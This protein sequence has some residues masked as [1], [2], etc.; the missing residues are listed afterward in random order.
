MIDFG[1]RALRSE[2]FGW[3]VAALSWLLTVAA[4]GAVVA[5][6]FAPDRGESPLFRPLGSL[7]FIVTAIAACIWSLALF[8]PKWRSI[9]GKSR[10]VICLPFWL[11]CSAAV[12]TNVLWW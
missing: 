1:S 11:S 7:P 12:V 5:L 9:S 8:L 6:L 2:T 10:I 4:V 3:V